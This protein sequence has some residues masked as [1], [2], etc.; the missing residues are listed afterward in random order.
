MVETM[1]LPSEVTTVAPDGSDVRVLLAARGG[2]MAHFELGPNEVSTAIRHQTVDEL[3]YVVR[4]R[5]EMWRRYRRPDGEWVETTVDI[6]PDVCLSIPV[7]TAFQFRSLGGEPLAAIGVTMPPW[8]GDDEAVP[9]EGR[10]TPTVGRSTSPA[11]G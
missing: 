8:P 9:V 4:G 2:G 10:W 7:G 5:G 1:T 11:G 6:H 3:W